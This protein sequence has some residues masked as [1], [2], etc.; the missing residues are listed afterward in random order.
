MITL[1][2]ASLVAAAAAMQPLQLLVDPGPSLSA[3]SRRE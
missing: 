1:L 3:V 2:L